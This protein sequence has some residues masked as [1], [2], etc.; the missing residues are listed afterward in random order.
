MNKGELNISSPN[1]KFQCMDTI[2]DL[3]KK[4]DNPSFRDGIS[5]EKETLAHILGAKMFAY[6]TL[7]LPIKRISLIPDA[8]GNH[9]DDEYYVTFYIPSELELMNSI[10]LT[11][12]DLF[13]KIMFT[14]ILDDGQI[15]YGLGS[16]YL[17]ETSASS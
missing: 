6:Q 16:L 7:G 11:I 9:I 4:N 5:N 12:I 17:K 14:G 10:N 2:I 13:S 8:K 15:V 1:F 3:F